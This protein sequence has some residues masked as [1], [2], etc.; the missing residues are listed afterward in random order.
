M[1]RACTAAL[2]LG[3]CADCKGGDG[4]SPAGIYEVV[5]AEANSPYQSGIFLK[6]GLREV[7]AP[8]FPTS[9]LTIGSCELLEDCS[10]QLPWRYTLPETNGEGQW[11]G[12]FLNLEDDGEG[13]IRLTTT[14]E[15]AATLLT[16]EYRAKL[17]GG[18]D[19]V[20]CDGNRYEASGTA[21][22]ETFC[23]SCHS[24]S[25]KGADRNGAP[26]S[27]NFDDLDSIRQQQGR[28]HSRV[29]GGSMPPMLVGDPLPSSEERRELVNWIEC[30]IEEA[31]P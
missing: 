21:F 19:V 11:L 1:A 27:V 7:D 10:G 28:I 13:V 24:S 18:R 8:I 4:G 12:R 6:V 5:R 17:E 2:I 26:F 31:A 30:G 23:L 20:G 3:L 14:D 22:I 16:A 29:V 15:G 25:R 9:Y